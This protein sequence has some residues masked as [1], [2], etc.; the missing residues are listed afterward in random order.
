LYFSSLC[1][2]SSF[3][4]HIL[5]LSLFV[6]KHSLLIPIHTHSVTFTTL[7]SI[8]RSRRMPATTRSS[9]R[10]MADRGEDQEDVIP[11]RDEIQR[12]VEVLVGTSQIY[13]S[14][15]PCSRPPGT[16]SPIASAFISFASTLSARLANR[17]SIQYSQV[18]P[19]KH[20]KSVHAGLEDFL[21]GGWSPPL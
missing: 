1:P 7:T 16:P 9:K 18:P 15:L 21:S 19:T 14:C 8:T 2:P 4:I 20:A 12:R 6:Y 10:K 17:D 11:R 5:L 3:N 13:S